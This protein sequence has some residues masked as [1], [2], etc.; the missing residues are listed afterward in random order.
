MSAPQLSAPWQVKFT[1]R[2]GSIALRIEADLVRV[3]APTGTPVRAIHAL[4]EQ[5]SDWIEQALRQQQ[6]R[7]LSKQRPERRYEE[8]ELWLVQ[9][10][11][12]RLHLVEGTPP[13]LEHQQDGLWLQLPPLADQAQRALLLQRWYQQQAEQHWPDRL[14]HWARITG[15]QPGGLKIRPYKSR[16]GSCNSRGLISLNTLLMMAPPE[17]LDYV[18]VHEL[19]HLRHPNHGAAFWRLVERFSPLPKQHRRWLRAHA[20]ELLF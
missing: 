14:E 7:H 3:L 4:L 2:K 15:L 10:Q 13:R 11:P 16:W 5:R 12:Q 18:I 6:L 8:G 20:S 1:R 9:G 19:C 17:T